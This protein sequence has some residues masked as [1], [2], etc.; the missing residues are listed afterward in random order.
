MT[1]SY[2]GDPSDSRVDAI[3]FLSGDTS[4]GNPM[5]TDEEITYTS[6]AVPNNNMAAAK[7]C[8]AIAARFSPQADTD[9]AGLRVS[10]SQRAKAFA[11]R[12]KELER[13]ACK[14]AGIVVGGRL[15]SEKQTAE[16]DNTI[17]QPAFSIGMDDYDVGSTGGWNGLST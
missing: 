1:W 8:R 16:A 6:T 2:S 4:S 14:S 10:A 12:A 5:V 9:N 13:D 7:V 15:V 3:R 11:D 17:K